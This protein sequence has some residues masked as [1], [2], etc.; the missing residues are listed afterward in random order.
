MQLGPALRAARTRRG[1]TVAELATAC[2]LSKGFI[3]QVE[4]DRTSPSLD[5]LDR[6]AAALGLSVVDLL[7]GAAAPPAPHV[8]PGALAPEPGTGRRL[9]LVGRDRLLPPVP[10]QTD[11]PAIREISPPGAALRSYVVDLPPGSALGT[12]D[13]Q[14]EGEE[15]L[16]VLSGQV[17]AEQEGTATALGAGDALA[18]TPGRRHRL[19]NRAPDPARLLI[20]LSGPATL[21][22]RGVIGPPALRPAALPSPGS[23]RLVAMRAARANKA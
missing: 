18:W 8:I 15:S 7:R 9:R 3:S 16:V 5:T 17:V 13:H 22:A 11:G 23:L 12:P 4:N 1:W 14:H 19:L 20:H 2:G 10:V 6:L 21:G